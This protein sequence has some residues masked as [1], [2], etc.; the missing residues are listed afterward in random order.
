[1][2]LL[3]CCPTRIFSSSCMYAKR[4]CFPVQIEGTQA[5]LLDVLE[6]EAQ[7]LQPDR[8]QDAAE[9]VNYIRA[10]NYGLERLKNLPLSLRLIREIHEKLLSEVRGSERSPGEFRRFQNWIWSPGGNGLTKAI[11]VPP[12]PPHE[13]SEALDN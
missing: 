13:M 7:A 12:P 11:F 4:R 10:T 2:A 6:F 5:S 8:P 3:R 9:V 1:M